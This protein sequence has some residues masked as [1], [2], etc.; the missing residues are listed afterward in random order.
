MKDKGKNNVHKSEFRNAER[1]QHLFGPVALNQIKSTL[2][3]IKRID[4]S[5]NNA[6]DNKNSIDFNGNIP[7]RKDSNSD[8][9]AL[10]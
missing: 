10:R 7:V 3:E 4:S 1:F 6:V 2:Q 8:L 5:D 9:M